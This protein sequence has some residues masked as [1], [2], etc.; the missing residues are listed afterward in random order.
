LSNS[1]FVDHSKQVVAT[2][3]TNNEFEVLL[4]RFQ[5][6]ESVIRDEDTVDRNIKSVM[7]KEFIQESI[8]MTEIDN[9]QTYKPIEIQLDLNHDIFNSYKKSLHEMASLYQYNN[10]TIYTLGGRSDPVTRKYYIESNTWQ[11]EKKIKINRSDYVALMYKDKRILIMGG[12]VI[13]QF[14]TETISDSVELINT[15]DLN[16]NELDFKLKYP[17]ANFGAVYVNHTIYVCGGYNGREVLNHFEYFD[18]KN[19]KWVDLPKM[20]TKR[21]EFVMIYGPDNCIYA[22]GGSD[23]RE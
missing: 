16:I 18:K 19:K 7:T 2:E 5:C 21:K 23:D 12:K 11:I 14:N 15:K 3:C 17:R 20:P 13:S 10:P 4:D 22:I 9:K 6:D 8:L 1:I